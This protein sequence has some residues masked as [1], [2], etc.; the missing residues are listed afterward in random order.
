MSIKDSAVLDG[1]VV[2]VDLDNVI[3][4]SDPKIREVIYQI[5]GVSLVQD[6]ITNYAYSRALIKRGIE[7]SA[8]RQIFEDKAHESLKLPD[9]M[10][11]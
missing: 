11:K 10:I 7:S 5:S 6:E 1:K 4:D 9:P 8:A 3:C 2:A